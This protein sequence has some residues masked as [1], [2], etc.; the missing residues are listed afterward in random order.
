MRYSFFEE[1]SNLKKDG[2]LRWSPSYLRRQGQMTPRQKRAVRDHWSSFGLEFRYGEWIDL[3]SAFPEATRLVLEIGF[4]MG[5][6]LLHLAGQNPE[7]GILGIEV[8]QPGIG[9]VLAEA[10]EADLKNLRVIRGDARLVL[11]DYLDGRIFDEVHIQFPDPWPKQADAHRRLVQPEMI[12]LL[13]SR[14]KPGAMLHTVTDVETYADHVTEIMSTQKSWQPCSPPSD[15]LLT[16]Y[17]QKGLDENR[18]IHEHSF[19]LL[20]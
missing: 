13:A 16:R 12:E 5:D 14:M 9:A 15:R 10:S 6:H 3:R 19:Q 17:E 7:S 20:A 2:K 4:G 1:M 18:K 8:H 11:S